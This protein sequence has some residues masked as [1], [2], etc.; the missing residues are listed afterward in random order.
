M[1]IPILHISY[2]LWCCWGV[3]SKSLRGNHYIIILDHSVFSFSLHVCS[4][5]LRHSLFLL[6]GTEVLRSHS[7]GCS[8]TISATN[9]CREFR[10][11]FNWNGDIKECCTCLTKVSKN[12]WHVFDRKVAI[13]SWIKRY[14][15]SILKNILY[16]CRA[17]EK[18]SR[19]LI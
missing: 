9:V 6:A 3:T 13:C 18:F 5:L 7:W 17:I 19:K 14:I 15:R 16:L 8:Y 10:E 12:L 4:V 2:F 11:P 1:F